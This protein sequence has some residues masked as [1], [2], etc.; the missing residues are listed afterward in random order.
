[1]FI[2]DTAY[3]QNLDLREQYLQKLSGYLEVLTSESAKKSIGKE[4]LALVEA[5]KSIGS[6]INS[7]S[8]IS[9]GSCGQICSTS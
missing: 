2:K 9:S 7:S 1:M 4:E 3:T 6:N 5:A 8:Q